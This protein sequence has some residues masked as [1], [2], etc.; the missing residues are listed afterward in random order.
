MESWNR[1]IWLETPRKSGADDGVEGEDHRKAGEQETFPAEQTAHFVAS[2]DF[3]AREFGQAARQDGIGGDG[4]QDQGAEHR[5]APELADDGPA[6]EAGFQQVNQDRAEEGA[7]DRSRSAEDID[8][9]DDGGG[10][11]FQLEPQARDHGD[12]AE[13]GEEHEARK[14]RHQAGQGEGGKDHALCVDAGH[15]GGLGVRAYGEQRA[16]GAQLAS[17]RGGR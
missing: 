6:N 2:L 11:G 12:G 4:E 9:A 17:G 15:V 1:L 13:T 16:G 8:A 10:D 14:A 7:D 3:A 5:L